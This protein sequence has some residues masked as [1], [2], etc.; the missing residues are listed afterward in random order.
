MVV[1]CTRRGHLLA[2]DSLHFQLFFERTYINQFIFFDF[3][4]FLPLKSLCCSN[5][6]ISAIEIFKKQNHVISFQDEHSILLLFFNLLI[7][8]CSAYK[9][10]LIGANGSINEIF[11]N[12]TIQ[13]PTECG[14][15]F[16]IKPCEPS[17]ENDAL[18]D[19]IE[20][21]SSL[22]EYE[23]SVV[24]YVSGF[25]GKKSCTPATM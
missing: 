25:I 9:K 14:D 17:E 19:N 22:D 23:N 3:S 11:F 4:L 10:L 7:F 16:D 1:R 20:A 5:T 13:S 2:R 15:L 12:T 21:L 6:V 18:I 8:C 24:D